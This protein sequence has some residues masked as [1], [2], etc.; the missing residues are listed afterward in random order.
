[1]KKTASLATPA[2]GGR[3]PGTPRVSPAVAFRDVIK[4][5]NGRVTALDYAGFEIPAAGP[6]AGQPVQR[7]V[8][9][10]TEIRSS[11]AWRTGRGG[12]PGPPRGLPGRGC[13]QHAREN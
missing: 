2:A 8:I 1:M 6:G 10:R 7:V 3:P 4:V 5:Y 9:G 13:E 12:P 11:F